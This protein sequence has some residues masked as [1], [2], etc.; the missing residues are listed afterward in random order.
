MKFDIAALEAATTMTFDLKVGER[1][2]G[3]PVGFRV[4]GPS[5]EQ[6]L[7]AAREVKISVTK[8]SAVRNK[9]IDMSTDEGAALVVDGGDRSR[10]LIISRCVV[11]IFG[12]TEGEDKPLPFTPQNLERILRAMPPWRDAIYAAIENEA[13]FTA[14]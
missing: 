6:Y 4:L 9:R 12:F 8:E 10:D 11:D 2:D 13:N 7:S 5:S 3:S 14:G 1:N